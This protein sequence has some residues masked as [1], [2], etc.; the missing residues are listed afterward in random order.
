MVGGRI[1]KANLDYRLKHPVLLPKE[2]HITHAIIRDHHEKVPRAGRGMTINEIRN[3]GYWIINWTSTVKSVISKCV[4]CRK[5]RGKICQQKMENLPA[6]RLS[7]ERPFTYC[8]VDMFGP[9]LVKDGRMIQKRYGAMFTCLSSRAVHIE[10][11][12]NL[13]IDSFIQAL[14]RLI[15]RR[16]NVRMIRSENGT[17]YVGASIELKKTFGEMD[18]KSINDF[19]MELV[20]EWMSWKCNP[21][22]ASNMGG[23][24]ERQI[25]SAGSILS[26]MLR[27]HGESLSNESLRTLLVEI[28][29]IINS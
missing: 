21:P 17:K 29:G 5:L 20:G 24:W 26:A 23:V 12:S 3:H 4:D 2:G 9:F 11:T 25:R 10:V 15:R 16:G 6:D 1:N 7:E 22:M 18:E 14:R 28:E 19:L 13:T 8:G 27:N